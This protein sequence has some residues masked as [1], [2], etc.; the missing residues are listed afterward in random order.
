MSWINVNKR[1]PKDSHEVI[2]Y[3]PNCT[4]IGSIL[5]GKYFSAEGNHKES[6]TVYDFGDSKM[7]EL[8]THWM[9]MLKPPK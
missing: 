3:A 2:V 7:N 6:W 8:V 9:P 5:V 4:I 1:K